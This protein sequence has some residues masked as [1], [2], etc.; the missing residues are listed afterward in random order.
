MDEL[1]FYQGAYSGQEIDAAIAQVNNAQSNIV[2]P[3]D[4]SNASLLRAQGVAKAL[5]AEIVKVTIAGLTGTGSEVNVIRSIVIPTPAPANA[6][7]ITADHAVL[8]YEFSDP[9]AVFGDCTIE[10]GA[11]IITFSGTLNGSTDLTIL[12]GLTGSEISL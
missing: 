5:L 6:V 7:S 9:D 11:N 8:W 10:T 1:E 12:L 2:S 4:Y 3:G